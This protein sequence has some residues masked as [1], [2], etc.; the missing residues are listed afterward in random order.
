MDGGSGFEDGQMELDNVDGFTAFVLK[1][2]YLETLSEGEHTFKV[3]F[4]NNSDTMTIVI[5]AAQPAEPVEYHITDGDSEHVIGSEENVVVE[6]DAPADKITG[7][8]I[9]GEEVDPQ[10]YTV[11]EEDGKTIIT[12]D[13]EYLDT[14]GKGEHKITVVAE[15]GKAETT[16]TSVEAS[17][18]IIKGAN[19]T[20]VKGT[21]EGLLIASDAPFKLFDKVKVDGEAVAAE[22][23]SAQS[24]STEITFKPEYLD[25]LAVGEHTVEIVSTNGSA[26]TKLTVEEPEPVEYHITDGANQTWMQGSDEEVVLG[27]DAP[28]DMITGLEIDG[29]A[30]DP[31]FYTVT[32]EDGKTVITIDPNYLETLGEGDH[33]ITVQVEDGK[34][35][36]ILKIVAPEVTPTPDEPDTGDRSNLKLTLMMMLVSALGYVFVSRRKED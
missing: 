1:T 23:Y 13:S 4:K 20:W 8:E 3:D 11:T 15:D 16:V 35:E 28:A 33:Q 31:E 14:L 36:T 9:D 19:S 18:T 32:E 17:Y 26:S 30:V 22:N 34:A 24:G 7:L 12:I 29:E 2:A 25:S 5:K 21:E 27:T 10:Y 6:T